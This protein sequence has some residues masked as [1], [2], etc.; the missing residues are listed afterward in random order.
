ML[1]ED[2]A[3]LGE[4]ALGLADLLGGAIEL[5]RVAAGHQPDADGVADA[6]QVVVARAEQDRRLLAA[7][8]GEAVRNRRRLGHRV[9]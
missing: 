2:R 3:E 1:A 6:A 8:E 7:V 5:D 4:D 9:S